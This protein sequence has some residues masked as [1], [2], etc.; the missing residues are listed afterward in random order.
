MEYF[1]FQTNL[2]QGCN[3][4]FG[5]GGNCDTGSQ[6]HLY[7]SSIKLSLNVEI[8]VF[9]K[10]GTISKFGFLKISLQSN[11]LQMWKYGYFSK[12]ELLVNLGFQKL[13][14]FVS[15]LFYGVQVIIQAES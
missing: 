11:Y 14:G 6:R 15:K 12:M 4:N 7:Q 3:I 5:A 13:A 8:W 2:F 1:I 10:N 9:F